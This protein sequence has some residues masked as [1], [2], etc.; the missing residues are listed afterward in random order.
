[1]AVNMVEYLNILDKEYSTRDCD[2]ICRRRN[3]VNE[4]PAKKNIS[5]RRNYEIEIYLQ[6]RITIVSL[7]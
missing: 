2:D 4:Y 7:Q 3:P 1:M 5:I 6:L